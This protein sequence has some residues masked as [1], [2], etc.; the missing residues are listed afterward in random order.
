MKRRGEIGVIPK[1]CLINR[2]LVKYYKTKWKKFVWV[3]EGAGGSLSWVVF[4]SFPCYE[5]LNHL[6]NSANPQFGDS[7]PLKEMAPTPVFLPGESHR[8]R[9][10]VGYSPWGRKEWNTTERLHARTHTHTRTR[11][12][13]HTHTHT[14]MLVRS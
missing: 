13:T 3:S 10:L 11:T 2:V 4:P 8:Q 5:S 12:H 14:H 1:F 7:H 6:S 9:S